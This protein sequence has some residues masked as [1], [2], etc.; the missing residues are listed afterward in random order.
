[1]GTVYYLVMP[2][3]EP[4][5][6]KMIHDELLEKSGLPGDSTGRHGPSGS[7]S[8]SARAGSRPE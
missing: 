2:D 5:A 6:V 4:V 7:R 1:M 3:S 8:T